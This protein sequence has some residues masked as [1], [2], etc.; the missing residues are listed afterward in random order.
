[1]QTAP[2]RAAEKPNPFEGD[3]QARRAGGKLYA[4][5]CA[6]CHGKN[7]EGRRN[8]P[9]L[10]QPEVRNAASGTL[11]FVLRNGSLHRGM[12]SFAHLPEAQRAKLMEQIPL[13]RIGKAEDVADAVAFLAGPEAAYITGHVIR[14]NGG[15]LMG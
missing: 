1:M 8:V 12:P 10:N 15:M 5:E 7:R 3:E 13:G 9:P 2:A 4:R 14:V 11:F 6:S